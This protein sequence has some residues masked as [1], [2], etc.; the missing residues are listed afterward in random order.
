MTNIV[1]G[2][3]KNRSYML[4]CICLCAYPYLCVPVCPFIYF[5]YMLVRDVV[6]GVSRLCVLTFK[7]ACVRSQLCVCFALSTQKRTFTL[8]MN[9]VL[10][11]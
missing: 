2:P 11:L 5:V 4:L 6:R 1:E 3:H 9:S 7:G 10:P 8:L